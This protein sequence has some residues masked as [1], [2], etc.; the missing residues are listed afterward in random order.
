MTALSA[1]SA[2]ICLYHK[3]DPDEVRAA[4][5]S[6]IIDQDHPPSELVAVF[7]GPVSRQIE[8][9]IDEMTQYVGVKKVYFAENRGHGPAR[10]AGIDHTS[11]EWSAVIDA[12][13]ISLPD[14]FSQ[15]FAAAAMFPQAAVIGAGLTEFHETPDGRQVGSTRF[16][17][18]SPEET[19][20]YLQTRSPVA[21][22][23]AIVR[24]AAIQQVGNYQ[25][26]YNNEDYHLWIRLTV[27][28]YE[29]R[30]IPTSVLLFRTSPDLYARRGGFIYWLNEARLQRYS[31]SQGTTTWPR[32]ILGVS[33][34]FVVQVL[35][36]NA[37][38]ESFYRKCL[39]KT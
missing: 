2:L 22:P 10:A 36:P 20:A 24:V 12:D 21:Q 31:L 23:T 7:D 15:L 35:L 9:V 26:W 39:R 8:A 29:I 19:T 18:Q 28:G 25:S 3:N 33:L 27:A 37:L 17:P 6:A 38:R 11:Y 5:E 30:N 16:Y 34:R 14:R 13:D 1:F 32:M 4:L